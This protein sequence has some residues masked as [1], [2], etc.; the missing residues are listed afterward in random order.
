[1]IR[2]AADIP[3][4]GCWCFPGGHIK[5]GE[6]PRQ[7]VCRELEEELDIQ[8]EP[9]RRLKSV[10]VPDGNY[11]LAVWQV[12]HV[13]GE[14]RPAQGEVAEVRWLTANELRTVE[15]SLPSNEQVFKMLG[16]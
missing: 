1:M 16:V 3:K 11:V 14:I 4:S 7:A 2:R 10:R 15:P 5:A 9:V 6:T 8:V 12:R 13:A